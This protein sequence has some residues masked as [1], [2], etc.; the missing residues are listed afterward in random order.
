[1]RLD[2]GLLWCGVR[3]IFYRSRHH[4]PALLFLPAPSFTFSPSY[5]TTNHFF[6]PTVPTAE[7]AQLFEAGPLPQSW[8][9]WSAPPTP[10]SPRSTQ[11]PS[12]TQAQTYTHTRTRAAAVVSA[13]AAARAVQTGMSAAAAADR[14]TLAWAKGVQGAWLAAAGAVKLL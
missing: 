9:K 13:G 2:R 6:L 10:N 14:M 5:H 7:F 8:L 1:M 11:Q 4:L 3:S 12:K